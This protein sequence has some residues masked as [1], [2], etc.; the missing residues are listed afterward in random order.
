MVE[1]LFPEEVSN[2]TIQK[3]DEDFA[4]NI[5]NQN[6][7]DAFSTNSK[8]YIVYPDKLFRGFG[9]FPLKEYNI[10]NFLVKQTRTLLGKWKPNN[11]ISLAL[12]SITPGYTYHSIGELTYKLCKAFP[13]KKIYVP[14]LTDWNGRELSQST[15]VDMPNLELDVNSDFK[16]VYDILC[17]SEFSICTDNSILHILDDLAAPY[18]LLDPQFNSPAFASRWRSSG[19]YHSVPISALVDDIIATVKTQI[20]VPETQMIGCDQIFRKNEDWSKTLILK[21]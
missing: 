14:V 3:L 13:D 17:K 8:N 9:A 11:Y 12:N 15:Y 4:N 5:K 21:E 7:L 19:F 16:K 2:G 6:D 10:T 20:E 18:L 1:V